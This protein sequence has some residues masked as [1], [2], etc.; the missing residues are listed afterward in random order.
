MSE[1]QKAGVYPQSMGKVSLNVNGEDFTVQQVIEIY[2]GWQNEFSRSAILYSNAAE[3]HVKYLTEQ[4]ALN[5]IGKILTF[6]NEP[7]NAKYKQ[8]ADAFMREFDMNADRIREAGIRDFNRGFEKQPNY[9]PIFRLRHQSSGGFQINTETEEMARNSSLSQLFQKLA[10]GFT[11]PR[12]EINTEKQQPISLNAFDNWYK[13]MKEEEYQAGLGGYAADV[14]SALTTTTTE[15]ESI[16]QMIDERSGANEWQLIKDIYNNSINDNAVL[17]AEASDKIFGWVA[18]ARSFAYV[19]YNPVSIA[20]Q[21]TSYFLA[22]PYTNR[23]HLFRSLANF[24]EMGAAG[25]GEE[26]LQNIYQ[27]YLELEYSSGDPMLRTLNNI[28]KYGGDAGR[29]KAKYI[30]WAYKGAAFVD[31]WTKAIVFDAVYNSLKEQWKSE[32]DAIRLA[33]RAVQD[34]QPTSNAREMTGFNRS[35]VST[36]AIFSQFMNALAPIYNAAVFDVARN[37]ASPTWNNT[38]AAAWTMLGVGMTFVLGGLI[39][40]GMKGRLPT[41][42]E[43]PDGYSDNWERWFIDTENENLLNTIPILNSA[44]VE[45]YRWAR[46]NRITEPFDAAAKTVRSL[47]SDEGFDWCNF[48]KAAALF[49]VPIPYSGEKI[50]FQWLGIIDDNKDY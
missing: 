20:A 13:A 2:I 37:I 15:H 18:K 10:D 27:K 34:I 29:I 16:Q 49:G 43:R 14:F 48:L 30:E 23:W 1:F 41:C 38:K 42:E 11:R 9:S 19:A 12:I 5:A 36:K 6:I 32:N 35:R 47:G 40:D 31:R 28:Y 33:I 46:G 39:K 4:D 50:I 26:F 24:L 17:E 21:F 7:E 25:R 45:W 44:F 22:L 3:R 8:A